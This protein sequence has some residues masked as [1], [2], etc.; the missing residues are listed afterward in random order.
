MLAKWLPAEPARPAIA[1]AEISQGIAVFDEEAL[2]RRLMGDRSLAGK[3]LSGFLNEVPSQLNIL[4]ERLEH[5]EAPGIRLQ[6]HAL[7]GAASTVSAMALRAMA[8]AMEQAGKAGELERCGEL[9]PGV[10]REFERFK[11]A[12]RKAG[13]AETAQNAVEVKEDH[14]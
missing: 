1:E 9:L 10:V 14:R 5:S 4:R 2:V 3:V 6:A 7:K 8:L 12:V 11:T 13:W